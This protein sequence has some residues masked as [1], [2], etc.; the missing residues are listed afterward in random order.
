V[1]ARALQ[2]L[3]EVKAELKKVSWPSKKEVYGTT[4]VV[5]ISVFIFAAFFFVVDT[6]LNKLIR[7]ILTSFGSQ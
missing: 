6:G 5:I 7:F 3:S 1:F 4:T 2:F